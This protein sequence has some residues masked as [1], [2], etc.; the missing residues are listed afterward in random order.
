[1]ADN[2]KEPTFEFQNWFDG[3]DI[4]YRSVDKQRFQHALDAIV[5][6]ELGLA[7]IGTNETVLD[8]YCRM[9]VARLRDLNVF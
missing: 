4:F 2:K 6:D 9:L 8:H 5:D 7:V 3:G 1:M